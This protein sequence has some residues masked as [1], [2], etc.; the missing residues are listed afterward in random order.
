MFYAKFR[1][2]AKFLAQKVLKN[3]PFW[4]MLL[5]HWAKLLVIYFAKSRPRCHKVTFVVVALGSTVRPWKTCV[6]V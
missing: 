4:Q 6:S 5:R 2:L 1:N 3:S